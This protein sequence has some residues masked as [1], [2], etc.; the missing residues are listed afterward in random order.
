MHKNKKSSAAVATLPKNV[1]RL[2]CADREAGKA[3]HIEMGRRRRQSGEL[4]M[5]E[6]GAV[7]AGA[8][9]LALAAYAGGSYVYNLVR[10]SSFKS[11]AQLFHSGVLN[12]TN[13]DVDFSGETL[14]TLAQNHA[15]DVAGS[16]VAAGG[17]SVRGLF[18]GAL[19]ATTGTLVTTN[20]AMILGYPVPAAVC[21]LSAGA[22]A[23]AYSQVVI[24]GTT[25][26]SPNVAFNSSTAGTACA[27]AGGTA[28]VQMYVSKAG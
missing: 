13:T 11:E 28:A 24:N 19:S 20:D 3:R 23:S 12:A 27:S 18:G 15:F 7:L 21:A 4:S 16:R 5:I 17:A 6:S 2:H 22:L 1:M 25:I 9:L 8:A 14:Q 10:A 26:Y